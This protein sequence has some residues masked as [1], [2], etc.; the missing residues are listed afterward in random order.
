[1]FTGLLYWVD[2]EVEEGGS[3]SRLPALLQTMY[4]LPFIRFMFCLSL[5]LSPSTPPF[6]FGSAS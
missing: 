1:M 3:M 5:Q 6:P 2:V 4:T